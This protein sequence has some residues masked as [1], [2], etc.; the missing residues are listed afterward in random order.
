MGCNILGGIA[1]DKLYQTRQIW[2]NDHNLLKIRTST[3]GKYFCVIEAFNENR[4][5][6]RSEV[7]S[8]NFD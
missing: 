8:F 5:S 4:V 1:P 3:I 6:G 7:M 2:G